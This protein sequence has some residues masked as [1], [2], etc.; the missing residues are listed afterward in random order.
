MFEYD[1]LPGVGHGC[2]HNVSGAMSGLAAGGLGRVMDR[3]KGEL[4]LVGTPA[5]ETNGSKVVLAEKGIFDGMDLAMMIHSSDIFTYAG[6]RSLA[7]DA[8]EFRFTG[9]PAHAAGN[10]GPGG[11]P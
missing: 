4:V 1:A 5:E 9:K 3:I 8:I 11:M 7:M 6:Y 10:P 2:G